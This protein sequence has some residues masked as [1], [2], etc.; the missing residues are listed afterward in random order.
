MEKR[1]QANRLLTG[2]Q[3]K[4]L[5]TLDIRATLSIMHPA[6]R[7]KDLKEKGFNIITTMIPSSTKQGSSKIALYTLFPMPPKRGEQ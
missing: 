1:T 3:R 5:S 4:S 7:V 2:L 6:G